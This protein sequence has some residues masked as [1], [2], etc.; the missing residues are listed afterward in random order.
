VELL[1]GT[2]KTRLATARSFDEFLAAYR[3][4][5]LA[6]VDRMLDEVDLNQEYKA[7][8]RPLPVR[9]LFIDDC[10]ERGMEYNA[11]GA[12][13]NGSVVNVGGLANAANSLFVVRESY[14]G[15]F[16]AAP[17]EL[18]GLLTGGGARICA[19][20]PRRWTSTATAAARWT[21]WRRPSPGGPLTASPP[22][23]A[24]APA[25]STSPPA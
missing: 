9:T 13:Y 25:A 3:D 10:L 18:A 1:D 16:G 4:D 6:N 17:A 8:Y 19:R 7:L 24:A 14:A 15:R 21:S 5:V 22:V 2:I 12:R 20:R 11:G 23:A